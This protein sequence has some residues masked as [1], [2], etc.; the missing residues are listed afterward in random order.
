MSGLDSVQSWLGDRLAT[1][2]RDHKVPGAA[3]AV[4]AGHEVV[5][6]ATGVLSTSTGVEATTDSV[7]QVGSITKLWTATLVMQLVDEGLLDLD[8]PV[9][10]YVPEF[11]VVDPDA[12]ATITTRQLL[13]HVA[14][15]EGDL[16]TD[17]GRGDDCVEK[18]LAHVRELDQLFPPGERF[19]YNNAGYVVLGRIVEVLRAAPYNAVLRDRLFG[20]LGL[21]HAA[22][23]ADEAILHRAAVGHVSPGPDDDPEP[24]PVW[25]LAPSNAPAGS[26]LAMSAR[27]LVRFAQMHLNDG[28][29]EDGTMVL[30]AASAQ[31][32]RE[33]AV[34]LPY[35]GVMGDAWGLGFE[36]FDVAGGVTIGHDGGTIGQ[37]A[38]LRMVPEAGV[39]VALL[40]NGGD[41][42]P[43]YREVVGAALTEL[44]GVRLPDNPAPPAERAPIDDAHR[45]VGRY[46]A[47]V[48]ANDV[49]V[50]DDG[51][52]WVTSTPR[53]IV[54]E[55]GQ[56]VPER[57]ELVR[58]RDDTFVSAEL[59]YGMHLPLA[60]VGDDGTG[61]AKYLHQGRA[62]VRT[63]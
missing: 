54:A 16:F 61:R 40:T 55:T 8:R 33:R 6:A 43:L 46:E 14:G 2:A 19:S 18:Y 41:P 58:L 3:V 59:R 9:Q 22:T 28:K 63:R 56:A 49:E 35:L 44:A 27:D 20:P 45:F 50:D 4:L 57:Y 7:F 12:S 25:N 47:L 60:F 30:T 15:F 53:G 24:A 36:L 11:R 13:S 52:L 17:T 29:A 1:V 37:A 32:M 26:M 23:C 62:V 31:A 51:R 5:D 34:E 21:R 48:V 10:T 42:F 39:A 38:F